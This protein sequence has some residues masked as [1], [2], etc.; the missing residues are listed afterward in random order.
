MSHKWNPTI[1]RLLCL[2]SYVPFEVNQSVQPKTGL[3]S[4]LGLLREPVGKLQVRPQLLA[5]DCSQPATLRQ[6]FT[7][8][9]ETT[10]LDPPPGSPAEILLWL[11]SFN[12]LPCVDRTFSVNFKNSSPSPSFWRFSPMF[13]SKSFVVL[14]FPFKSVICF[15][16]FGQGVGFR[17][18]FSFCLEIPI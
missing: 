18:S 10:T 5:L 9:T 3:R 17:L 7:H 4:L 6:V 16:W 2:P 15:A 1:C 14:L 11:T 8:S 12:H 13:L